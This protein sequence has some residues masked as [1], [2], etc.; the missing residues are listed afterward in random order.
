MYRILIRFYEELNDFL[1]RDR[2]KTDIEFTFPGRRSAK[3]LIESFGVPHVEVDLI[4][5]NGESVDF[6]YIIQNGDRISVYPVFESFPVKNVTRLRDLPLRNPR[7][8]LDVHLRKLARRLRLLGFDADFTDGRGDSELAE[9]SEREGRILLTRDRRLLMRRNVSRG[10]CIRSTDPW[11]QT[12]EVLDRLRLRD[13]CRPFTRCIE[14]NGLIDE[15]PK[16]GSDKTIRPYVPEGV[17]S[18]CDE[19][20]RC[21]G[22]GKIYWKGSHYEKLKSI[23]GKFFHGDGQ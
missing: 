14:C 4:L 9:I 7:F 8:V 11:I 17:L 2:R 1:P 23:A 20:F 12:D 18:W 21:S 22:C 19:Y 15:I 6:G 3:D 13:E 10:I 5:V 16:N